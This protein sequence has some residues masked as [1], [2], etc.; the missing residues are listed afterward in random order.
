MI[1]LLSKSEI[2]NAKVR[3]RAQEIAEG[4]KISKKVDTLRELMAS[5]EETLEKFRVD[6]ILKINDE[7]SEL[8]VKKDNILSEIQLLRSEKEKGMKQIEKDILSVTSLRNALDIRERSLDIRAQELDKIIQEYDALVKISKD[9]WERAK[10]HSQETERLHL[11]SDKDRK[12]AK[13]ILSKAI[14]TKEDALIFKKSLELSLSDWGNKLTVQEEELITMK[15]V[16]AQKAKELADYAI[17]LKD[18]EKTLERELQRQKNG[19]C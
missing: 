11:L 10:T 13:E 6:A 18:R 17:Q 3:E 14:E 2:A 9:E 8:T 1:R 5:E 12:E 4:I 19:K 15:K 7:I 16:N